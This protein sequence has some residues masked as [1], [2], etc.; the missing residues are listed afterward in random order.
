MSIHRILETSLQNY[1]INIILKPNTLL[2]NL[3]GCL[4]TV[5]I[6]MIE[7]YIMKYTKEINFFL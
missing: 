3:S 5:F 4:K 7:V 2:S 6:N 1:V